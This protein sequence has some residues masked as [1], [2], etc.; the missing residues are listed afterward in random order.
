MPHDVDTSKTPLAENTQKKGV[1]R[2]LRRTRDGRHER[3]FLARGKRVVAGYGSATRPATA[4]RRRQV[5]TST[6]PAPVGSCEQSASAQRDDWRA[7]YVGYTQAFTSVQ[8]ARISAWAV[9]QGTMGQCVQIQSGD[10]KWNMQ[11]HVHFFTNHA[12]APASFLKNLS[13][14]SAT[15]RAP[16]SL[17]GCTPSLVK[18]LRSQTRPSSLRGLMPSAHRYRVHVRHDPPCL[19]YVVRDEEARQHPVPN[20]QGSSEAVDVSEIQAT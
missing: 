18:S 15:L 20:E 6:T 1:H 8:R 10:S 17:V 11:R 4:G 19:Q 9:G 7:W 5:K 16:S 13:N 3:R 2:L 12:F 14:C